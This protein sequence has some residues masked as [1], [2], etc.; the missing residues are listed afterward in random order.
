MS[1]ILCLN[2]GSSSLKVTEFRFPARDRIERDDA[3]LTLDVPL[4]P[5][6]RLDPLEA[7]ARDPSVQPSV[8][9]HR[10]VFGGEAHV[11][12][13][14]VTPALLSELENFSEIAPLHLPLELAMVRAAM[15]WF[16]RVPHVACFDTAF[17]AAMPDV[18]Q[19]LPIDRSLWA[20]GL[21]RYGFHGL[22]YEFIV[23]ELGDEAR[24]RVIVAHLGNGA[25]LAAIRDGKAVDTTMGFSPLG[26]AMMGT[27]PGDLDPGILL[28]LLRRG[29]DPARLT[30]LLDERSGLFGVSQ[31]SADTSVLLAE[32]NTDRRASEAIELFVYSVRKH[33]GALTAVLGGLDLLVFTGG[34]GE[35]AA[36]IRDAI[37]AGLAPPRPRVR[38]VPTNENLT[39][40]R[41]AAALLNGPTR[42]A[43]SAP[44]LFARSSER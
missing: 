5:D 41:H 12:P 1:T 27:R 24:G 32:R 14:L 9:A 4:E 18:A 8:V 34:I 42:I 26:G 6:P 40:A 31:T 20:L 10:L 39:I 13:E 11:A 37:V 19:R 29:Y 15:E 2:R 36:P 33:I 38:V 16:P 35:H 43:F 17:H 28:Y 21:R 44:P 25:S 30:A 3:V 22:S 23:G 7:I